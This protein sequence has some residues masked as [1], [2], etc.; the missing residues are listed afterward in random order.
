[1][2]LVKEVGVPHTPLVHTVVVQRHLTKRRRGICGPTST[3][4]VLEPL[5]LLVIIKVE[6]GICQPDQQG[7]CCSS[8]IDPI[9]NIQINFSFT[10]L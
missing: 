1:M 5:G 9:K 4:L 7:L 3:V 10:N 6:F 8:E 2:V